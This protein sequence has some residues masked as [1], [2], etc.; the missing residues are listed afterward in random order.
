MFYGL[1]L[2]SATRALGVDCR[3]KL[4]GASLEEGGVTSSETSEENGV[5]PRGDSQTVGW[6]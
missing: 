2:L 1:R 5:A 6:P 4:I 3:I